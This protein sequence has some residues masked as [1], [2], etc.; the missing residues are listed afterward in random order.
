MSVNKCD[1]CGSYN[2]MVKDSR[3]HDGDIWRTRVCSD[4]GNRIYTIE[5]ERY[6][7]RKSKEIMNIYRTLKGTLKK[8]EGLD[9]I[10]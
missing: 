10:K 4:C 7:L 5:V 9:D 3:N 8:L 1:K 6:E 2:V